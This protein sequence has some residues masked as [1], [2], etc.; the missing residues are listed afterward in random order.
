MNLRHLLPC[1]LLPGLLLSLFL[2]LLLG[3]STSRGTVFSDDFHRSLADRNIYATGTVLSAPDEL[4]VRLAPDL[5]LIK[6]TEPQLL[7]IAALAVNHYPPASRSTMIEVSLP[8][9]NGK[10]RTLSV[11]AGSLLDF[12]E[13]ALDPVSL[14]EAARVEDKSWR[15]EVDSDVEISAA[16]LSRG[17]ALAGAGFPLDTVLT[18]FRKA[19]AFSPEDPGTNLALGWCLQA[20]GQPKEAIPYLAKAATDSPPN[21]LPLWQAQAAAGDWDALLAQADELKTFQGEALAEVTARWLLASAYLHQGETKT[22]QE[23]ARSLVEK[24]PDA[25]PAWVLLG[26]ARAAGKNAA[27]ALRSA[28]I[29]A[30]LSPLD[31]A[32]WLEA[33]RIAES[34]AQPHAATEFARKAAGLLPEEENKLR[35]LILECLAR[36]AETAGEWQ[37]AALASALGVQNFPDNPLFAESF[38]SAFRQLQQNKLEEWTDPQLLALPVEKKFQTPGEILEK[39]SSG[40][41]SVGEAA[42]ALLAL[43]KTCQ[44]REGQVV[45][46]P[47]AIQALAY[48][49]IL[50]GRHGRPELAK[51]AANKIR[52]GVPPAALRF[53]PEARAWA[54]VLDSVALS[55]MSDTVSPPPPGSLS[56]LSQDPLIA[57][58]PTLLF[59]NNEEAALWEPSLGFLV[60]LP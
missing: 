26:R 7:S 24:Y 23:L 60:T 40:T 27:E 50:A 21:R 4:S 35:P 32:G 19:H 5:A 6:L 54:F 41:L 39:V 33:A 53:S 57:Q 34:A 47:Q 16:Y 51:S 12:W 48:Y 13:G 52:E 42:G 30:E 9:E 20:S 45:L 25:I 36:N 55:G 15:P 38:K 11:P 46:S 18:D 10:A 59:S 49:G 14:R 31:P 44:W 58:Y 3:L 37:V 2:S 43:S 29:S 8:L 17:W 56:V 1:G 22:A 28:V